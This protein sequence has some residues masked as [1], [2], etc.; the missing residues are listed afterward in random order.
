MRVRPRRNNLK[1]AVYRFFAVLAA[2]AW[3]RPDFGGKAKV[4]IVAL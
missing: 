3:H 4:L 2:P 1:R